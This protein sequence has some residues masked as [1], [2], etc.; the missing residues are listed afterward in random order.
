MKID[1]VK[2]CEALNRFLEFELKMK[3]DSS[4]IKDKRQRLIN[5]GENQEKFYK[6]KY[7]VLIKN[8]SAKSMDSIENLVKT[9]FSEQQCLKSFEVDMI[10]F[11][12]FGTYIHF[13]FIFELN[14]IEDITKTMI[15]Y[16]FISDSNN[17]LER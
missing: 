15:K 17:N 8:Y 5:V 9:F 4:E 12:K 16:K 10:E 11:K 3:I 1:L 6:F 7:D 14:F 2:F 13:M